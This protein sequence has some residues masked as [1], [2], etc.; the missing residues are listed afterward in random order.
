MT[1]DFAENATKGNGETFSFSLV[2][3]IDVKDSVEAY[4]KA[5]GRDELSARIIREAE[6]WA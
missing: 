5:V 2:F 1:E 6:E 3:P 4:V